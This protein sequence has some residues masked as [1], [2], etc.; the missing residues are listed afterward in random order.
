MIELGYKLFKG[1]DQIFLFLASQGLAGLVGLYVIAFPCLHPKGWD[2]ASPICV[3]G[4]L[5]QAW[6][7]VGY[8]AGLAEWTG[9][10]TDWGLLPQEACLIL[11][12]CPLSETETRYLGP[13]LRNQSASLSNESAPSWLALSL[14]ENRKMVRGKMLLAACG[15]TLGNSR[16]SCQDT[17]SQGAFDVAV[18]GS[19]T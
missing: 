3:A 17:S 8:A 15:S 1:R 5:V 6:R 7:S 19:R 16:G 13:F 9:A 18:A 10:L 11:W 14:P 12:C 4:C 2:C